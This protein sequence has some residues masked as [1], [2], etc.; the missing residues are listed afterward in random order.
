MRQERIEKRGSVYPEI[1][2]LM[3]NIRA[4][5]TRFLVPNIVDSR[6]ESSP[7]AVQKRLQD[8]FPMARSCRSYCSLG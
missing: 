1:K 2:E 6:Q 5:T 3:Q 8:N 4:M 7:D